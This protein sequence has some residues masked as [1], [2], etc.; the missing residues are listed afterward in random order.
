MLPW[1]QATKKLTIC[2]L[3]SGYAHKACIVVC[4]SQC[5]ISSHFPDTY[6]SRAA[7]YFTKL[8]GIVCI[9]STGASAAVS[10]ACP[11]STLHKH[12]LS[13]IYGNE[14]GVQEGKACSQVVGDKLI[15]HAQMQLANKQIIFMDSVNQYTDLPSRQV[16][17]LQNYASSSCKSELGLRAAVSLLR[18]IPPSNSPASLTMPASALPAASQQLASFAQHPCQS[19]CHNMLRSCSFAGFGP[20]IRRLVF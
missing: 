5:T 11:N 16:T 6:A 1:Q 15:K 20:R 13:Q 7:L 8:E 17:P 12:G 4:A 2:L 18:K 10:A 14:P 3:C 9:R 19:P